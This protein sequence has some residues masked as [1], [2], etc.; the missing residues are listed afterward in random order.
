MNRPSLFFAP[1][2]FAYAAYFCAALLWGTSCRLL[3]DERIAV[4]REGQAPSQTELAE[5]A[6][7]AS[8]MWG[9]KSGYKQNQIVEKASC[10]MAYRNAGGEPYYFR[11]FMPKET[12]PGKKYPLVIWLHGVGESRSDNAS[13]LAHMQ[14]SIESLAGPD[15]P[16]FFLIA[17][18]CPIETRS[19][20][21]PDPRTPHG[22]TPLEMI[23]LVTEALLREYPVDQDRISLMGI[24][25]GAMA[26]FELI[27]QYPDR[28]SAMAGCSPSR[29]PFR[30]DAY[31]RVAVWTFNNQ[32]DSDS[33][34]NEHAAEALNRSGIPFFITLNPTGGHDTWTAAQR[35][36]HVLDWLLRQRRG[37]FPFPRHVPV[38]DRSWGNMFLLFGLPI[39]ITVIAVLF[40]RRRRTQDPS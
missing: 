25:S 30:I 4:I 29:L 27:E 1:V 22:E 24:C 10:I 28:F 36:D 6:A 3:A 17:T 26:G 14:S 13:Q 23:H 34:D 32:D 20:T 21:S 11:M 15:R 16:D 7:A 19:W 40:S 38:L 5:A 39:F 31:R 33:S 2:F 9:E 8:I 12:A 37:R 35:D 18:Q